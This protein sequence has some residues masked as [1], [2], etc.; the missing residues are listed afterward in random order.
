[1]SQESTL[2]AKQG[3]EEN[4]EELVPHPAMT[5]TDSRRDLCLPQLFVVRSAC[6]SWAVQEA[7]L[8]ETVGEV[9]ALLTFKQEHEAKAVALQ[10]GGGG[11]E[12]EERSTVK[13]ILPS[14]F[15]ALPVLSSGFS[16]FGA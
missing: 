10:S 7:E 12:A 9:E 3:L 4:L 16:W 2:A 5:K 6:N 13:Q 11:L 15:D 1:M 14:F 8:D